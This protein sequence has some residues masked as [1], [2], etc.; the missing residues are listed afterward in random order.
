MDTSGNGNGSDACVDNID[1]ARKLFVDDMTS[2]L[3]VITLDAKNRSRKS[4]PLR[5]ILRG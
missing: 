4:L 2:T 3:Q 1:E 5:A